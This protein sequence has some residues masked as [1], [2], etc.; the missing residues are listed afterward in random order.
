LAVALVA[1]L[2]RPTATAESELRLSGLGVTLRVVPISITCRGCGQVLTGR[3]NRLYCSSACRQLAYR[4]RAAGIEVESP[5]A[6]SLK[7]TRNQLDSTVED[8]AGSVVETAEQLAENIG[9]VFCQVDLGQI[10]PGRAGYLRDRLT[11]PLAVL[12]RFRRALDDAS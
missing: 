2:I 6:T 9:R 1:G 8:L 5:T 12:E 3:P 11:G 10:D 4:R 7:H